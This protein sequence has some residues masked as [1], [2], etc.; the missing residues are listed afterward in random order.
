VEV[1]KPRV[2][3]D[4]CFC[5]E[6]CET[7]SHMG[8]ADGLDA[9]LRHASL[10]ELGEQMRA[11]GASLQTLLE[12][13]T[14]GRP[15]LLS[16]LKA[17]GVESLAAR[18]KLANLLGKYARH[19]S[20]DQAGGSEGG[21]SAGDIGPAPPGSVTVH[22]RCAGA[23]GGD[24]CPL[25]GKLRNASVHTSAKT[26]RQLYDELRAARGYAMEFGNVR[27]AASSSSSSSQGQMLDAGDGSEPVTDGMS[28]MIIGPNRGG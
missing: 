27:I 12:E 5:E 15:R 4:F 3:E 13:L 20:F 11:G 14:E 26:V 17:L 2:G 25:N 18:Q 16:S 7:T 6:F 28:L 24:L 8:E 1:S 22:V 10:P 19:G 21:E 23:L 9:L